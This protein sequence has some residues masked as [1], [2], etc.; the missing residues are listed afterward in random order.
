MDI[1]KCEIQKL[2]DFK[3]YMGTNTEGIQQIV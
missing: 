1:R 2:N 3:G